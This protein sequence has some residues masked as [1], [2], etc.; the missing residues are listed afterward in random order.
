M[1]GKAHWHEVAL[2]TVA[3]VRWGDTKTTKASYVTAGYPAFSATGKD[4]LLDHYDHEGPGIVLSAIGAQCGKSWFT[5]GRWSCIKNTIYIKGDSK[6]ADTRYL[7]FVLSDPDVWP[8]RGAAQPFISQTDAR[9]VQ[10][11]LP[12]LDTQR[13][14]TGILSAYDDLIENNERR[15]AIL[16]EM[17]R[18]I[19]REWFVDFR[20]PG[21]EAV[22]MVDTEAGKI[23]EGWQFGPVSRIAEATGASISPSQSPQRFFAHYS[24][25][26][27]DAGQQPA[28]ELGSAI[29]SNKLLF[30][31][32]VVLLAKLNPRFDRTWAITE[33]AGHKQVAS[34]EYVPLRPRPGVPL[35]Y[36]Q[37][38]VQGTAFRDRLLGLAQGTSTS[39]Q[40]AKPQDILA[41]NVPVPPSRLLQLA[42]EHL[43]PLLVGAKL[44]RAA[45]VG[46][47]RSRDLILP[48]LISGD[49]TVSAAE[50]ALET[51]A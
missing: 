15:I 9:A 44:A 43:D 11:R 7:S 42:D 40:R 32:P 4:G 31:P 16:E 28:V 8:K 13:R 24:L 14:I 41:I 29:Q 49:L 34:T 1:T 51:A 37:C 10:I 6:R 3:E 45:N 39:H 17:A 33:A 47:R 36:L 27:F 18:R 19:F 2:G 22:R 46:L 23:P 20:F 21:H 26:A 12:P 30:E 38:A 35:A 25:P 48:R 50:L 5:D